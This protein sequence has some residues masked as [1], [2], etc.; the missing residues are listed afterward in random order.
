MLW[1]KRTSTA[2]ATGAAEFDLIVPAELPVSFSPELFQRHFSALLEAA[3]AD[4][5]AAA[6][7]KSLNAKHDLFA[8][9]LD[10]EPAGHLD[11]EKLEL[12]LETVFTARRK[13]LPVFRRLGAPHIVAQVDRL[14]HGN[15]AVDG[16]MRSF[17]DAVAGVAGEGREARSLAARVRGAARDFAAELLHFRDP[18]RYPLMTRWVWDEAT[19]SGAL[20]EFIPGAESMD[21][22]SLDGRPET[23]EGVRKWFSAQIETQGIYRDVPFWIDLV[24]VSGYSHYFRAMTGGMMGPEFN[25]SSGPEDEMKR[26][27]GIDMASRGGRSL[28][29]Q[30]GH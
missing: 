11:L 9:A 22:L 6:Y 13:L 5:G 3:K 19:M 29:R 18:V 10:T 26:L 21:K 28:A 24:Q 14:L 30:G 8:V 25:R 17:A 4:G 2:A 7:L 15:G 16:R 12:L 1:F 23:F 20:R 27:L